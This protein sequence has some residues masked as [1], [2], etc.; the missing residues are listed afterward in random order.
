M[1]SHWDW[2]PVFLLALERSGL[3]RASARA[4]GLGRRTVYDQR[5]RDPAFA[6]AWDAALAPFLRGERPYDR[7]ALAPFP[8]HAALKPLDTLSAD[9][10][11]V[12]VDELERQ[13]GC[14]LEA[15][16]AKT[17][18]CG[19]DSAARR[20]A[21][22]YAAEVRMLASRARPRARRTRRKLTATG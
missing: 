1:G 11:A 18:R 7:R 2:P 4:C 8:A 5:Q 16:A 14:S 3:I 9:V 12:S 20:I 19:G 22:R 21:A 17:E 6:A 10:G 15:W 13:L